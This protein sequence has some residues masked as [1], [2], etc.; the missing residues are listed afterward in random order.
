M[1]NETELNSDYQNIEN[2]LTEVEGICLTCSKIVEIELCNCDAVYSDNFKVS[3]IECY[4]CKQ[5]GEIVSYTEESIKKI[6]NEISIFKN[7]R[8]SI[9]N[10]LKNKGSNAYSWCE[11]EVCCCVGAANCSLGLSSYMYKKN[12]WIK[13]LDKNKDYKNYENNKYQT[14]KFFLTY[15]NNLKLTSI[16]KRILNLGIKDSSSCIDNG[17][18]NFYFV[19]EEKSEEEI[20]QDIKEIKELLKNNQ[21]N[22]YIEKIEENEKNDEYN[23]FYR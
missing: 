11:S 4:T 12:D 21:I 13:W 10:L 19:Y 15:H 9:N 8:P 3:D 18:A 17:K 22:Y 5:C 6:D 16:L 14:Y 2:K 23:I 1:K 7:N 20:N